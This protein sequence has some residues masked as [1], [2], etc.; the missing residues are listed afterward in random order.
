MTQ[1][2][3][4]PPAGQPASPA[5][6]WLVE[7]ALFRY[8][9]ILPLLRHDRHRDGP[10]QHLRDAIAAQTHDIPHSQR[11]TVSEVT[12]RRWEK[13]YR[14]GGFEAL[15]PRGRTDGGA[16]R[17]IST[18][19]LDRA[20]ALKRELPSRSVRTIIDILQRDQT[21]PIPEEHLAPRTLSR[22]LAA[23]GATTARLRRPPTAHR[24]FERSHFGDLWQSDAMDGPRLPDTADPQA[25]RQ[26]FLF[27]FLDDYTRLVPHAQFYWNEQLPRLEDCLKHAIL[28]YGC[29]LAIYADQGQ[30]YR[31]TQFDAACATLGVQRILAKPYSP[32]AKGKIERFFRFV[33]SD[34]LPELA[35]SNSVQTLDDLNQ[36]LLAWLE[37]VY[38][39]KV[40][41]ETG[42]APLDRYRQDPQ[43]TIRPVDPL[44]LRNAFLFR[45][46]RRVNKTG[47]VHLQGN[48]YTVPGY[49]V[50]QQI[51]LRYDP[52][53]LTQVEVWL[54]G[55]PLVPATIHHLQTA[56]QPGLAL[57]PTPPAAPATGVDYLALLRQEHERLLREQLPP[58]PFTRLTPEGV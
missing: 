24:R 2:P 45:A 10:K 5:A 1:N 56:S 51:E 21:S 19:T 13:A 15:K 3:S 33:Q 7:V 55:Q 14:A 53:D 29:P 57:D 48:R 40:H 43:P 16:A 11:R 25:Q 38:H 54:R 50:S 52:F 36:A 37:V 46:I 8:A 18:V 20:E 12:L 44:T 31:A 49:L 9:L 30:V 27:A 34:F 39:R 4:A 47:Q 58:I 22:H 35:C 6:T 42:Q 17:A 41:S 28:R 23:R 26:T 32:Q